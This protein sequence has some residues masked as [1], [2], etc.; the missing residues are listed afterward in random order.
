LFLSYQ[1]SIE[2]QFEH[3]QRLWLNRPDSPWDTESD[4]GPDPLVGQPAG[5]R[6]FRLRQKG[7]PEVTI[8]LDRFVTV[9]GGGYYFAPSIEALSRLA[10]RHAS[11]MERG[12][13]M[14]ET[15]PA[16]IPGNVAANGNGGVAEDDL[17]T[18]LGRFILEQI[19][20]GRS[21]LRSDRLELTEAAYA[22]EHDAEAID[23]AP[24]KLEG[25]LKRMTQSRPV[26]EDADYG[27]LLTSNYWYFG[28][29]ARRVTKAMRLKITYPN[30]KGG[31]DLV[32]HILIGYEGSGGDN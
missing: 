15:W 19:P 12:Q 18:Q 17:A 26:D 24:L 9:T 7:E 22:A 21:V 23:D 3:V 30:P 5:G 14:A 8:E 11:V 28:G 4:P 31:A 13:N 25:P 16:G 20:Y 27:K 32:D 1:A 29:R 10:D 2:R 6:A